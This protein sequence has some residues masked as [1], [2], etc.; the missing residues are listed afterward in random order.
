MVAKFGLDEA[1]YT[2]KA[3]TNLFTFFPYSNKFCLIII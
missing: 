3:E 1:C 2:N